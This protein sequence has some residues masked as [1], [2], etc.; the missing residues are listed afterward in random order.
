M[1]FLLFKMLGI[2]SYFSLLSD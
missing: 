1:M 2:N